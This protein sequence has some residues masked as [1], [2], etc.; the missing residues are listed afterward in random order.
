MAMLLTLTLLLLLRLGSP[1]LIWFANWALVVIAFEVLVACVLAALL[2]RLL[3]AADTDSI[4]V[5]VVHSAVRRVRAQFA[6]T[7]PFRPPRSA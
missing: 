4:Q 7:A 3:D 6:L 1:D 5:S 2:S